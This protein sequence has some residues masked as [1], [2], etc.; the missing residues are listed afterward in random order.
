MNF[1]T[2][3]SSLSLAFLALATTWA[4]D[5]AETSP[6]PGQ[7]DLR[8]WRQEAVNR[9][10]RILWNHDGGGSVGLTPTT[11][12]DFLN[13]RLTV[14]A[15]T[16]VDTIMFCTLSSGFGMF[17][18]FTRVGQIITHSYTGS[19][20]VTLDPA[21]LKDYLDPLKVVVEFG[22]AHHMEVFWSM[23][24]NDTHDGNSTTY[25][26][27]MFA[28]NPLKTTHPEYLLGT[29]TD[30]PFHGSWTG[31]NY[32]RPEIRDLAFRYI[33]EVCQN[34]DVD[35][36]ELDFFRHPN[37][38]PY[39]DAEHGVT[40]AQCDL[41]TG[42][43]QRIRAMADAAGKKRGRP[44]LIAVR[45]PDSVEYCRA[46]G[47]DLPK[48]LAGDLLDLLIPGGYIRM[49]NWN[50]MVDLGHRYGVKVYADLDEPRLKIAKS[51]QPMDSSQ[52]MRDTAAGY[53]GRA[54]E[55][56]TAKAD[57]IYLFDFF[58]GSLIKPPNV[59]LNEIGSPALLPGKERI[60][61]ASYL[62]LSKIHGGGG[63]PHLPFQNIETLSINDPRP[64]SVNHPAQATILIPETF[65]DDGSTA[66]TLKVRLAPL[67]SPDRLSVTLNGKRLG[68]GTQN[69]D[70]IEYSC[71]PA[72]F[73]LG[74]NHCSLSVSGDSATALNWQDLAVV[75]KPRP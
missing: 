57:G 71:H 34:Y 49:N 42:L 8:A 47:I 60:Y 65:A 20:V 75:A 26:P 50:T 21:K 6:P 56:L 17:S 44:I 62:G 68:S 51:G 74:D 73:V 18:H 67:P 53:R 45:V 72:D 55:A 66:L 61:F 37:F 58:S 48:W 52:A 41:M 43:M 13:R 11:V 30:R 70:W 12:Q 59:I 38:F 16:Q 33:E 28:A 31:V 24:M 32:E 15:N 69:G 27:K 10:R 35:G 7:E 4:A 19:S 1:P 40:Q 63:L 29:K 36:I 9:P 64:V 23:R 25:G 14:L 46:I 2:F 5:P 39:P 22:Q 3:T 54:V